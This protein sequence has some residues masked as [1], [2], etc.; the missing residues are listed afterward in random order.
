MNKPE[1]T[2]SNYSVSKGSITEVEDSYVVNLSEPFKFVKSDDLSLID[3][4]SRGCDAELDDL[5]IFESVERSKD[6]RRQ[7]SNFL[8]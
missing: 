6:S 5:P 2:L 3:S 1:D 4:V 8:N 7:F